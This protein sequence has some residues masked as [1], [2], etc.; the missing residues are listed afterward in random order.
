MSDKESKTASKQSGK[1]PPATGKQTE[2]KRRG[3]APRG[4]QNALKAGMYRAKR[5]TRPVI[6]DPCDEQG[7]RYAKTVF[8]GHSKPRDPRRGV[9]AD[10]EAGLRRTKNRC[11]LRGWFDAS[12]EQKEAA[13]QYYI[14]LDRK[15]RLLKDLEDERLRYGSED[16]PKPEVRRLVMLETGDRLTDDGKC[17]DCGSE[18]REYVPLQIPG[19]EDNLTDEEREQ[20]EAFK[21]EVKADEEK[22]KEE[23]HTAKPES[24]APDAPRRTEQAVPDPPT[25]E[26]TAPVT[27]AHR[28]KVIPLKTNRNAPHISAESRVPPWER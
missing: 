24:F 25:P 26:Q 22:R 18:L 16:A 12:G 14:L 19:V 15:E 11:G 28:A 20:A 27:A 21:A 1:E 23:R 3:G 10:I 9:L 7:R 6:S 2:A 17:P 4:N 13:R 5:R 8:D